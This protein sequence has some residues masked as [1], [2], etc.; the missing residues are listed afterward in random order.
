ML[1]NTQVM[2]HRGAAML[3]PENTLSSIKAAAQ[4]GVKWV[5]IDVSVIAQGDL[6]IFHDTLLDRCTNGQGNTRAASL[7][8]IES[9][10]AGS[11]FSDDFSG[12]Q[13]PTLK[14]A[15]ECIQALGLGLNLE[16]KHDGEDVESIVPSVMAMLKE[17][18]QDNE[19]LMISS[20]NHQALVMCLEMDDSRHLAQLY[21]G[22]PENWQT[23]L[24]AIQA[25]SLNCQYDL[26]TQEQAES[27]KQAG[28]K[29]LC[30]TANTQEAVSHHWQWGMDAVITDDPEQFAA[31]I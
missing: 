30:Y 8:Y 13:V 31:Y 24:E 28:Y 27:I 16:I 11:W 21:E 9:L 7:D 29:L 26:L 22:V 18:W 5:E 4:A 23:E 2:G 19:K 15:L 17:H 25:Y 1:L 14:A 3:A 10:D 12:E 20:F 6:V